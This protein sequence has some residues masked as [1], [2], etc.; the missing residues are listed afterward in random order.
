MA[1]FRPSRKAVAITAGVAAFGVVAMPT[2]AHADLLGGLLGN[3]PLCVDGGGLIS[4]LLGGGSCSSGSLPVSLDQLKGPKG[5]TG[6]TGPTGPAGPAGT[7]GRVG[8]RAEGRA[9]R[10]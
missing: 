5:D 9:R 7:P 2:P 3:L 1:R 4:G 8:G 10:G 6:A